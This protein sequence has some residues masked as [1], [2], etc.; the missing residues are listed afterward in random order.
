MIP[1]A[2]KVLLEMIDVN[3]T[4]VSLCYASDCNTSVTTTTTKLTLLV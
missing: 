3:I 2:L 4:N 1:K